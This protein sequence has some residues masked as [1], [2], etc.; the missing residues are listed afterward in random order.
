MAVYDL[1]WFMGNVLLR[2]YLLFNHENRF[3][4]EWG[5]VIWLANIYFYLSMQC[6]T[7]LSF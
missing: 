2:H 4:I 5:G 1:Y 3:P 6:V 7:K